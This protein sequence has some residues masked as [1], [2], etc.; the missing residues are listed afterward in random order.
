M[1]VDNNIL[2]RQGL[3][4]LFASQPDVAVV[5]EAADAS[6]AIVES[7]KLKPDLILIE[8]CV[9]KFF[10][11]WKLI[12]AQYGHIPEECESVMLLINGP[13][14]APFWVGEIL[15]GI[16]VPMIILVYTRAQRFSAVT[17][18]ALLVI[19]GMFVAR[20]D[21]AVAGQLVPIVGRDGLWQYTPSVIETPSTLGALSL[22]LLLYSLGRR[23]FPLE[24]SP[25]VL[26][27]IERT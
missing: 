23:L 17:A 19:V 8:P 15:F 7:R 4:K 16:L 2:F 26:K 18:A 25:M 22:S 12:T 9:F 24:D 20:Y 1:V 11:I 5:G 10:T 21:F 27:P 13:L 14:S 6:E 3:M